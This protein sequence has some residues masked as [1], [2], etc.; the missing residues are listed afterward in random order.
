MKIGWRINIQASE[1]LWFNG[2]KKPT[3]K[4]IMDRFKRKIKHKNCQ[5]YA[6]KL[7]LGVY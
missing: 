3:A 1:E 5:V 6:D 2:K 7:E 4:Q